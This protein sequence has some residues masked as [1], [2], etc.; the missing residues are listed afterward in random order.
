M[1]GRKEVQVA[2]GRLN[3][4]GDL[5]AR[6]S[7]SEVIESLMQLGVTGALKILEDLS[8]N[9]SQVNNPTNYILAATSR[10]LSGRGGGGGGGG[11]WS[12]G[13]GWKAGADDWG[14]SKTTISKEVGRLNQSGVLNSPISYSD[15]SGP[16]SEMSSSTALRIL[17]DLEHGASSVTN[18]TGYILAAAGRQSGWAGGWESGWEST[19]QNEDHAWKISKQVGWLNNNVELAEPISYKDV[20]QLLEALDTSTA[21][22]LLKDLENSASTVENPTAYVAA[23]ARRAGGGYRQGG[24]TRWANH[25]QPAQYMS[26]AQRRQISKQIGWLNQNMECENTISYS[27]V[28][29]V[30][31]A[32]GLNAAMKILKD[33]EQSAASVQKPTNYIIVAA[34]RR[35]SAGQEGQPASAEGLSLSKNI[36]RLNNSGVL[37]DRITYSDVIEKLEELDAADAD[38]ILADLEARGR[39]VENPTNYILAACRRVSAQ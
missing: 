19:H 7:F 31:S 29:D 12:G 14:S 10:A 17:H 23:A 33:L 16:L 3:N 4:S 22:K 9:A 6:I 36:G 28:I 5:Q 2:I 18:P 26:E 21:M 20:S 32:V 35:L 24:E 27:D 1:A 25:D 34:R 39:K 30:L 38:K 37:A 13:G 15:V 8:N 11:G